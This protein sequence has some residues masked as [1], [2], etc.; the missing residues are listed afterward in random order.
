MCSLFMCSLLL[1]RSFEPLRNI[2]VLIYYGHYLGF[3][4]VALAERGVPLFGRG[5]ELGRTFWLVVFFRSDNLF[6][7]Y[8]GTYSQKQGGNF[9]HVGDVWLLDFLQ[10]TT[11]SASMIALPENPSYWKNAIFHLETPIS[12]LWHRL[13]FSSM[14]ARFLA[15]P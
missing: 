12:M 15:P 7:R 14:A 11:A 13:I 4:H 3:P 8:K 10:I 9:S 1:Y 2:S 6:Q 5:P